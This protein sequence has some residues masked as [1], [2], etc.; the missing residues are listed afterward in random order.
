[1]DQP[2]AEI[3]ISVKD[4][5]V[6]ATSGFSDLKKRLAAVLAH[7]YNL[8]D[9]KPAQIRLWKTDKNVAKHLAE[10]IRHKVSGNVNFDDD[11]DMK[12]S[13][14]SDEDAGAEVE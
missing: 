14:D 7:N 2:N 6:S 11:E 12:G 13:E 5:A 3:D 4:V 9:L 1:M 8:P 10:Q